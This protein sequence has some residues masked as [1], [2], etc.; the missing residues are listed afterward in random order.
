MTSH[1][2]PA[3]HSTAASQL[4]IHLPSE[5]HGSHASSSRTLVGQRRL[6]SGSAP[7]TRGFSLTEMDRAPVKRQR[8]KGVRHS[9]SPGGSQVVV[10]EHT[11]H[12]VRGEGRDTPHVQHPG[13]HHD[14]PLFLAS[15]GLL[16]AVH[17]L[18]L[19]DETREY[20]RG[21]SPLKAPLV[22]HLLHHSSTSTHYPSSL[23]LSTL[24]PTTH[25][26]GELALSCCRQSAVLAC[27]LDQL[28]FSPPPSLSSSTFLAAHQPSP[29][30]LTLTS[31]TMSI[32]KTMKALV[33]DE[34]SL[35]G[36]RRTQLTPA[37]QVL[38]QGGPRARDRRQRDP[39]QGLHLRLL[40]HRRE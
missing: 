13:A 18:L 17:L 29:Q 33:Y 38:R 34:V 1:H 24:T 20:S 28:P 31:S 5:T 15:T 3:P 16:G 26:L 23:P 8:R 27:L 25:T 37:P 9:W 6:Q 10:P 22:L 12:H 35:T 19:A 36:S 30:P 11:H 14:S 40:R 4:V 21:M 7:S 32:P 39:A 2:T